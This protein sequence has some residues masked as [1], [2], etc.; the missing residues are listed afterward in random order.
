[1]V[2]IEKPLG[3][4]A[5]TRAERLLYGAALTGPS[6]VQDSQEVYRIVKQWTLNTLAFA[7]VIPFDKREDGRGAVAAMHAH[8]D[9]PGKMAKNLS[10]AEADLKNLHYKNEHSLSF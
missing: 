2:H 1:M 3:W 4:L 10:K 5:A 8:Y 6:F 9:G 7:W